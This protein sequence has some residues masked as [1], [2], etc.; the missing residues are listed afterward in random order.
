MRPQV[1]LL[2]AADLGA[3]ERLVGDVG[4]R[5]AA[6]QLERGDGQ[7]V[8]AGTG[9]L[10]GGLLNE[11]REAQGVDRARGQ[12]Q[13]VA[14]PAGEDLRLGA[15]LGE[16]LAQP[17][18]VDVEVL[19]GAGGEVVPPQ[20]VGQLIAA[21]G[22]V[23][24]KREHRDDAALLASPQGQGVA[25]DQRLDRAKKAYLQGHGEA[26]G[27][28]V[29]PL[30]SGVNPAHRQTRDSPDGRGGELTAHTSAPIACDPRAVGLSSPRQSARRDRAGGS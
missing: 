29:P 13:L 3:G 17:R 26:V 2:Q 1:E 4:E 19:G 10:A 11:L 8:R 21:E 12:A 25:V 24:V 16:H 6:P 15:T 28:K 30:T 14:A 20:T 7:P 23:G 5:R 22:P 9:G 18:D 27:A